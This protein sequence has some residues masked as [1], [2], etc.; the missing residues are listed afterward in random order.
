MQHFSNKDH[1]WQIQDKG[2][3]WE[4]ICDNCRRG[5][6]AIK[7]EVL[8]EALHDDEERCKFLFADRPEPMILEQFLRAIL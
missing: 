8:H 7:E 5:Y 2:V 1:Y 4:A 6:R 3:Y